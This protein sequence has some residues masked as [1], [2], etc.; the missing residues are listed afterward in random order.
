MIY[1]SCGRN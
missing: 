1:T